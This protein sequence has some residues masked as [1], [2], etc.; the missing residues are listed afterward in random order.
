MDDTL[1]IKK[2][3]SEVGKKLQSVSY[4]E[5]LWND[6]A[7]Y[8]NQENRV[9]GLIIRNLDV[10]QIQSSIYSLTSLVHLYLKNTNISDVSD[11]IKNLTSLDYLDLSNNK[12][13]LFPQGLLNLKKLQYIDLFDNSINQIPKEIINLTGLKRLDLRNNKLSKISS[14]L[15]SIDLG[16]R[17]E[18]ENTGGINLYNNPMQNPPIEIIKQ[19]K[20]AIINY[21]DV[22]ASE[23]VDELYEAKLIIIGEGGSGKTTLA[24]KIINKNYQ[25]DKNEK[26]TEGI[27]I[28]RFEFPF[29]NE[30]QK[31][32]KINIWDFG[33]QEIYHTTHQFFLT[34]RSL[35]VLVADTRKEDTDFFYWLN[36]VELLSDSSPVLIVQNEKQDRTREINTKGIKGRFINVKGIHSTNL[37]SNRG[38]EHVVEEIKKQI[39][40]LPHVGTTLPK[41]WVMIRE[42]LGALSKEKNHIDIS[43]YFNICS[44]FNITDTAKALFLS[45]YLHDLGAVLHF[46]DNKILKKT[47]ILSTTWGT[48]A[49]YKVLDNP[50][51]KNENKGRFTTDDLSL[52]WSNPIYNGMHDELLELMIKFELCY[53]I[54]DTSTFISPQLLPIEQ[55]EYFLEIDNFLEIK[56]EYVFMPKGIVS[57]FIV[58]MHRYINDQKLVWKEGVVLQR[59]N[60]KAEVVETYGKREIKIRVTGDDA[61]N[62]L[63]IIS[64]E[65]DRIHYK[66]DQI[67]VKKKIP[68]SCTVCRNDITPHFYD[69]EDLERRKSKGKTTVECEKSYEEVNVISLIVNVLSTPKKKWK[70]FYSYSH[71]DKDILENLDVHMSSLKRNDKID[72]WYDANLLPGQDWDKEIGKQLRNSNMIILLIS[73]NF[74]ASDFCYLKEMKNALNRHKKGQC[75][76]VP[77]LIKPC[78]WETTPLAS[79]KALPDNLKPVTLWENIDEAYFHIVSGINKLIENWE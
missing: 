15:M 56:Y 35:Y 17:W 68:C 34:K 52:I 7:Y 61:K 49:V 16:I 51:I 31:K 18:R 40:I 53:Q 9:I 30:N 79:L 64:E 76:V 24:N 43:E 44:K 6:Y 4:G 12:I 5:L 65:I 45:G 32:F 47:I 26:S 29:N 13:T 3:E 62:F 69:Y 41:S 63:T 66:F 57:K 78:L 42:K 1:A 21:F 71:K 36:I 48:D 22:V 20:K 10:N 60:S 11:D 55:P 77:I 74:I 2:I 25:L 59:N 33:G 67:K 38:L 70:V 46:Q 58:R 28:L 8:L 23:E 19:G 37:S 39:Q 73:A 75:V 54:E 72:S 50:K 27:D 14:D